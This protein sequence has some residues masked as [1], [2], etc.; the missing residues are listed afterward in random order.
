VKPA[1]LL[2]LAAV[3][4]LATAWMVA[5]GFY[6]GIAPPQP[7]N[8]VCPPSIA[9]ATSGTPTSG[10][11]VIKVINGVS[12]ANSAFTDDGQ[13]VIG[14]LPGSFDVTGKTQVTVDIKPVS[15]CPKPA[16]LHFST[17]VYQITA[18]APLVKTVTLVMR[19]S[20]L[21]LDPSNVYR[22]D[23]ADGPWTNIG[24]SPQAQLWTVDTKTDKLGFFAAGYPSSAVA[25]PSTPSAQILPI[26]IA[27]LIVVVLVAGVPLTIL[28]RR[29]AGGGA[30]EEDDDEDER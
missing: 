28:R 14:F 6:D 1:T 24:E 21:V 4:Y 30:D 13:V 25:P 27:G 20:N 29:R 11:L 9:G 26:V 18:D 2:A 8:F 15:P 22:S 16:G 10:H 7:Y 3:L 23:S 12:D 5:P 17:N 19:Y